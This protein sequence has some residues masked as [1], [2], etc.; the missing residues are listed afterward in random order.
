[1]ESQFSILLNTILI[2]ADFEQ[3]Q[4]AHSVFQAN[5]LSSCFLLSDEEATRISILQSTTLNSNN[6]V[7]IILNDIFHLCEDVC[8]VLETKVFKDK[9]NEDIDKFDERFGN[10]MEQ[11]I[12]LIVCLKAAPS[13]TPLSQLLLRLDFNY[14]FSL[15]KKHLEDDKA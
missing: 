5:V 14:W 13:T 3:I 2:Q 6:P 8:N 4:R 9:I 7:Y 10:L 12:N 15:K 11:L 1:L